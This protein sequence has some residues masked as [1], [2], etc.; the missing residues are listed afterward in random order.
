[1][2]DS[3]QEAA[4]QQI[5]P[6]LTDREAETLLAVHDGFLAKDRVSTGRIPFVKIGRAVRYQPSDVRA[7]I[8]ANLRASTSSASK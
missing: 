4:E 6:L 1:M 7:F 2:R 3:T 5:E 8:A